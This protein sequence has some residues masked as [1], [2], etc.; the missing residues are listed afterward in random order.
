MKKPLFL[1]FL[2]FI[3]PIFSEQ[4]IININIEKLPE[5]L[6][7]KSSNDMFK[8]YCK[9]V[10]DNYKL[11]AG[12]KNV[13]L[14]FYKYKIKEKDTL[15]FISG[16]CNIIYDTIA[17]LN[18]MENRD[19][20]VGSY[21][22]IPTAKGLF[23]PQD[24]TDTSLEKILQQNY[25]NEIFTNDD[26]CYKINGRNYVF[27][28]NKSFSPTERAYYLDDELILPMK[29]DSFIISSYF[30]QRKNPFSGEIKNHNG[31]DLAA[32]EGTPVYAVKNSDDSLCVYG[33]A[34]FGN[35]IILSHDKGSLMSVYAHLS[36][37]EIKSKQIVKKGDL[38]GYVGTTGMSTGPH[39]HFELRTGGIP[40]NPLDYIKL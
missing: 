25:Q 33:D 32:N 16:R 1:V 13:Q 17:T 35:Y 39:L 11:Q 12:G 4:T 29:K 21:I 15:Q 3:T 28:L 23:I 8:D 5:L 38:I 24:E 31:I 10:E 2:L 18:S 22:I 27:I 19:L 36:K 9:I 20:T 40:N 7:L 26:K 30:G 6:E 14:L 37:I 34:T